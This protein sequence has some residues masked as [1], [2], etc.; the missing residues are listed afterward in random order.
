MENKTRRLLEFLNQD[1]Q[2]PRSFQDIQHNAGRAHTLGELV[3]HLGRLSNSGLISRVEV[4]GAPAVYQITEKGMKRLQASPYRGE[5][6]SALRV[7]VGVATLVA[8][9]IGAFYIFV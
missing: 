6:S 4:Q 8:L 1:S 7:W 2:K 3:L 5:S 9:A